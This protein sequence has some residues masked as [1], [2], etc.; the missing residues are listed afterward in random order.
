M[1]IQVAQVVAIDEVQFFDNDLPTVCS[2]L[3][4]K[5]KRIIVA[6]LDMDY[7]GKPFGPVPELLAIADFV[8]KLRAICSYCG[9]PALYSSRKTADKNVVQLGEKYEYF[10]ELVLILHYEFSARNHSIY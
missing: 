5:G 4:K 3:A 9:N 8:T 2:E 6:G 10:V 7:T 1:L